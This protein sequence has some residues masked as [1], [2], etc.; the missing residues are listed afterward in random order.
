MLI[1]NYRILKYVSHNGSYTELAKGTI[2]YNYFETEDVTT[3]RQILD[4]VGIMIRDLSGIN[5]EE[6][7]GNYILELSDND[8]NSMHIMLLIKPGFIGRRLI[9]PS[10][11]LDSISHNDIL[12]NMILGQ[13]ISKEFVNKCNV[14]EATRGTNRYLKYKRLFMENELG[15]Y[16]WKNTTENKIARSVLEKYTTTALEELYE[17]LQN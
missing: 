2:D 17:D 10:K 9:K 16:I 5:L 11:I 12:I 15:E 13:P 14:L 4:G 6:S 3:E 7:P 8:N 1:D